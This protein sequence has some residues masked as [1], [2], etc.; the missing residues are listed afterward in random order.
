M[1]RRIVVPVVACLVGMGTLLGGCASAT[2]EVVECAATPAPLPVPTE[3]PA[4]AEPVTIPDIPKL[5]PSENEPYTTLR[6]EDASGV[7]DNVAVGAVTH[8]FFELRFG[9]NRWWNTAL[10]EYQQD[11]ILKSG[12]RVYLTFPVQIF[13][14]AYWHDGRHVVTLADGQ[15]IEGVLDFGVYVPDEGEYDLRMASTVVVTRLAGTVRVEQEASPLPGQTWELHITAPVEAMYAVTNPRFMRSYYTRSGWALGGGDATGDTESFSVRTREDP[16][17]VVTLSAAEVAE[18][19]FSPLSE[20]TTQVVVRTMTGQEYTGELL[21]T[22]EDS[23]GSHTAHTWLLYADR[24]DLPM[25]V[26]LGSVTCFL[27]RVS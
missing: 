17:T 5:S 14:R 12:P 3:T 26:V 8:D 2:P 23:A 27:R 18:I 1:N 9:L 13:R 25:Q 4:P 10:E 20:T 24:T 22:A 6:I 16:E 21:F 19:A 11:F 15:E 7:H